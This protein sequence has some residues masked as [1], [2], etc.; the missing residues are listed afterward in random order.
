MFQN[1]AH[2]EVVNL[3]LSTGF[4]ALSNVSFTPHVQGCVQVPRYL[5]S[6]SNGRLFIDFWDILRFHGH[7]RE[8]ILVKIVN[9]YMTN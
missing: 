8:Y 4:I 5:C 1:P 7:K 6:T 2:L 3:L 9:V